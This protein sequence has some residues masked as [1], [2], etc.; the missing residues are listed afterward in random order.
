[1]KKIIFVS[2]LTM[3]MLL[4]S[5]CDPT[6]APQPQ[7]QTWLDKPL[8][9]SS[10][11]N[12][13]YNLVFHAASTN[14]ISE[15]EVS[16]DG[17]V[18][19]NVAPQTTGPGG[20]GTTLFQAEHMWTP[21][22]LGSYLISVRSMNG[23]G[24]YGPSA[25]AYVTVVGEG[26]VLEPELTE[27]EPTATPTDEPAQIAVFGAPQYSDRSV[28]YRGVSCGPKQLTID[29]MFSDPEAYSVVIFYRLRDQSSQG[30]TEWSSAAM[31]SLG[32]G[33]FRYMLSIESMP[34]FDS[35]LASFLQ[36]QFVAT[37]A[38]G[39]ELART[40]VFSDVSVEYCAR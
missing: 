8:N 10:I 6:P 12:E 35:F 25:Q 3:L 5:A 37:D 16:V 22:G 9:N 1:M 14:G 34:E 28:Y 31:S 19:T 15:F 20:G 39:E 30:T 4:V 27:E 33:Y 40:D 2:I 29:V 32:D 23:A 7:H 13:P 18:E 38:G 24:D 17:V 26:F 11:L 36:V 21:P